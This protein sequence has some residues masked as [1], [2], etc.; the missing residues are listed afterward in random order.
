MKYP[1]ATSRYAARYIVATCNYVCAIM[2]TGVVGFEP[3]HGDTKNRCLT[4]WLHPN[5]IYYKTFPAPSWQFFTKFTCYYHKLM[6][7][8][9][10]PSDNIISDGFRSELANLVLASLFSVILDISDISDV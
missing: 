6:Q 4:A 1:A 10:T 3:T 8:Q 2:R 5:R 9:L 7:P